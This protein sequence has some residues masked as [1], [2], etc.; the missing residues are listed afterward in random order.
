MLTLAEIFDR[1]SEDSA[2][3][4]P[5]K[6]VSL[7]GNISNFSLLPGLVVQY[8]FPP[9][10]PCSTP[11]LNIQNFQIRFSCFEESFTN[12]K[13]HGSKIKEQFFRC[14]FC[15]DAQQGKCF[16]GHRGTTAAIPRA[17]TG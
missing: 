17:A 5:K 10:S 16:M 13:P 14:V 6:V 15:Y 8:R 1:K 11:K 2:S 12:T 7:T 9:L 3:S 4:D